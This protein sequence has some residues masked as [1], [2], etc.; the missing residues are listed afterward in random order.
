MSRLAPLAFALLVSAAPAQEP[1]AAT[2]PAGP[3]EGVDEKHEEHQQQKEHPAWTV[4]FD[5]SSL[6]NWTETDFGGGAP[7]EIED[8]AMVLPFGNDLTGVTLTGDA[9]KALP[10][11][12]YVLEL[13]A[14]RVSGND[15]FCGLTLPV[16]SAPD[17]DDANPDEE[18]EREPGTVPSHATVILGGWGGGLTGMSSIGGLDASKN[19]TTGF[20]RF[21]TGKWYRLRVAVTDRSVV[22]T[23]DGDALF[24]A[25]IDGEVVG[26]RSETKLSR[27]LGIATY[28]T[29]GAVKDIRVRP[30]AEKEIAE[31]DAKV[32]RFDTRGDATW[33]P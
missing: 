26:M 21:E 30:L 4:L 18:G 12:D 27:P 25:D 14:K 9:A 1:P 6:E 13:H 10:K 19:P 8:G 3:A 22:A 16:P 32:K 31:V 33:N 7:V 11:T 29:T 28:T 20:R 15:F 23:L 17:P 2:E 5:G 24:A